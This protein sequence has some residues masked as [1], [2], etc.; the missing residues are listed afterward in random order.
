MSSKIETINVWLCC[1]IGTRNQPCDWT[2]PDYKDIFLKKL[3]QDE[4]E[5]KIL[6]E[7]F[8]NCIFII[9]LFLVTNLIDGSIMNDM[10]LKDFIAMKINGKQSRKIMKGLY[11]FYY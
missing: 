10:L 11:L 4:K 7:I 6:A 2:R 1:L 5:F 9:L 8:G 3:F